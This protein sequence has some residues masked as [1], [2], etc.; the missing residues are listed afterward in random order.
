FQLNPRPGVIITDPVDQAHTV[1]CG[2]STPAQAKL[3]FINM[4]QV[5]IELIE[6][7]SAPSTWKDFLDNHGEGVHHIAFNIQGTQKVVS[8]LNGCGI[9]LVQQ[10]DYTGGKYSYLDSV[11]QLGVMLELLENYK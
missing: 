3:A 5:S 11:P 8:F 10:G 2:E 4:G 7:V 1:Y 6:P 9:P